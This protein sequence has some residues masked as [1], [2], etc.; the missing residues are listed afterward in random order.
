MICDENIKLSHSELSLLARGPKFSVRSE[1][2]D[3]EFEV[4]LESMITKKKYRSSTEEEDASLVEVERKKKSEKEEA[5]MKDN[6]AWEE[7]RTTAV[8]DWQEKT[9]S[10][11]RIRANKYKYN[12]H[13]CMPKVSDPQTEARHDIRKQRTREIYRD[14]RKKL[15]SKER[16]GDS[17]LQKNKN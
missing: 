4:E 8:F 2:K 5:E 12:K 1:L 7:N 17:K 11:A 14:V 6:I 16:E 3:E 10:L 9:I 15:E 13:V